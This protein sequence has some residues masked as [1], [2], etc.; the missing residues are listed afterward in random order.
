MSKFRKFVCAFA[1][2]ATASTF[3]SVKQ[4]DTEDADSASSSRAAPVVLESVTV[5]GDGTRL[6]RVKTRGVVA[7]IHQNV[8][9]HVVRS[10]IEGSADV[11]HIHYNEQSARGLPIAVSTENLLTGTAQYRVLQGMSRDT[12]KYRLVLQDPEDFDPDS[13][14]L[15]I[16]DPFGAGW[17]IFDVV[18]SDPL[19]CTKDDCK[20]VC[21]AGAG[22]GSLGCAGLGGVNL[23][24]GVICEAI[25]LGAWAK[26]VQRCNQRCK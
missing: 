22:V 16:E 12:R 21:A 6:N 8:Y 13:V 15:I 7:L 9:G 3:A 24:A 18:S 17:D 5:L 1:L 26:C 2:I 10:Q 4:I 14:S 20:D 23:P 11:R 25:I 19:K